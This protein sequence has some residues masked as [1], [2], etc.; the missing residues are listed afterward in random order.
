[1]SAKCLTTGLSR[2]RCILQTRRNAPNNHAQSREQTA[3][4]SNAV[5]HPRRIHS[6][7]RRAQP[8]DHDLNCICHR[9]QI[10]DLGHAVRAP[11][12]EP[13]IHIAKRVGGDD[14]A[15]ILVS[16]NTSIEPQN[17]GRQ[18][19]AGIHITKHKNPNMPPPHRP[20]KNIPI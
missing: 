9:G 1:M 7:K 17:I 3:A 11:G 5:N 20:P 12:L 4:N 2:R 13:E 14:H 19:P 18:G 16:T 6:R 10:I 15:T 8:R